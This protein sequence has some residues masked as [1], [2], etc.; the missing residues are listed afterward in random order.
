MSKLGLVIVMLLMAGRI[1]A[2]NYPAPTSDPPT[3][4][5]LIQ[6]DDEQAFYIRL[7]SQLPVF[8]IGKVTSFS[9]D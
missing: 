2:Q 7:D 1:N 8:I 5:V 9:R 6:A 4:F 3:Y